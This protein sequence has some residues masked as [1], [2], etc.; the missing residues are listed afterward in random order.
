MPVWTVP[1]TITDQEYIDFNEHYLRKTPNGK[2]I[3]L[4]YRI[5]IVIAT[6]LVIPLIFLMD[7]DMTVKFIQLAVL[8]VLPIIWISLSV[9]MLMRSTKKIM[10]KRS[11][12][13]DS[14]FS[15]YGQLI[16]DFENEIIIDSGER[17]EVRVLF[18]NV[19]LCY[20]TESMFYFYFGANQAIILP[21]R[22]FNT[23]EDFYE[24]QGLVHGYFL[25][26]K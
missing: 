7:T 15:R 20:E 14:H 16:F 5:S 10:K 13:G 23:A 18:Q 25:F 1:Y 22:L 2:K 17:A 19:G 26:E 11:R 9:R 12:N 3:L 8:A 24:F 6:I 21:Y 4:K